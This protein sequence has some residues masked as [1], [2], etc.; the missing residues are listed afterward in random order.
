MQTKIYP[1]FYQ[2]FKY[3]NLFINKRVAG[4]Y[5]PHQ[6][7]QLIVRKKGLYYQT[8]CIDSTSYLFVYREFSLPTFFPFFSK[9]K[10]RLYLDDTIK[11]LQDEIGVSSEHDADA[12]NMLLSTPI[13]WVGI[14]KSNG[15]PDA[16][17]S[18]SIID[19]SGKESVYLKE[20][21]KP[22]LIPYFEVYFRPLGVFGV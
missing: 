18:V 1:R 12:I 10:L 9:N 13:K 20:S 2:L 17:D 22:I 6:F 7:A 3:N 21:G 4:F 5:I 11:K 15:N 8:L 14:P 19:S 16:C